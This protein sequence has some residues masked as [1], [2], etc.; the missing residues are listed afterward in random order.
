MN[1]QLK[2]GISEILILEFLK[3][4]NYGYNISEYLNRY[5]E[6]KQ[7]SIYTILSRLEQKNFLSIREESQGKKVIKYYLITELG[8]EHLAD[9]YRQWNEINIAI[10]ETKENNEQ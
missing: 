4:E 8:Q 10:N 3:K 9:L 6:I 5:I 2:K 1:N 7:S